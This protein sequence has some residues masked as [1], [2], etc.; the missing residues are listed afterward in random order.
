MGHGSYVRENQRS[1]LVGV[2]QHI[3]K[4]Y[5]IFNHHIIYKFFFFFCPGYSVRV[6]D[7]TWPLTEPE[8]G[9][10]KEGYNVPLLTAP[11]EGFTAQILY[12]SSSKFVPS[13]SCYM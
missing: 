2:N 13:L 11:N 1:M 3:Y 8:F 9:T 6:V 10:K 4:I 5:K 12:T 7:D